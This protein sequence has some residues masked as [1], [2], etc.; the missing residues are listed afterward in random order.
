MQRILK[1]LLFL[2]RSVLCWTSAPFV[3][4][5]QQY[6]VGRFSKDYSI[7]VNTAPAVKTELV[8]QWQSNSF[9]VPLSLLK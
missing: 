3:Q 4:C 7:M 1:Y 2:F 5:C 8:G 9:D 6:T